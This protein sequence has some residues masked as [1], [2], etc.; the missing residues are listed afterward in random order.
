LQDTEQIKSITSGYGKTNYF[1]YN[2]DD[3]T[4]ET[5]GRGSFTI[6]SEN[7]PLTKTL[8][9]LSFSASNEV[10]IS[11]GVD[12][13][14]FLDMPI[15]GLDPDTPGKSIRVATAGLRIGQY[16]LDTGSTFTLTEFN[17]L[18]FDEII[19][20]YYQKIVNSLKRARFLTAYFDLN[21]YDVINFDF[22]KCIYVESLQSH[23]L[24]F[25]IADFQSGKPTKCT[26]LK[27]E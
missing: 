21:R 16:Y 17:G 11:D 24:V 4:F 2:N 12:D 7:I 8:T 1:A 25:N 5:V 18:K 19:I 6:D 14:T 27:L 15:Y 13:Y 9:N 23:F 22:A 26:L 20:K 10:T 3:L